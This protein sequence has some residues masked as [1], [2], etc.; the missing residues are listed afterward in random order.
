[1]WDTCYKKRNL[2]LLIIKLVSSKFSL[3]VAVVGL[4]GVVAVELLDVD[5]EHISIKDKGMHTGVEQHALITHTDFVDGQPE[6]LIV[7]ES[8][9]EH[10]GA[11]AH[12]LE[13]DD[14][15]NE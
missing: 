13:P 10:G 14:V 3:D 4:L 12:T 1:M 6:P 8:N 9:N 5:T 7:H 2:P 15:L 11:G